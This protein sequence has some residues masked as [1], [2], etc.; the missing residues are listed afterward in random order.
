MIDS[1]GEL[2]EIITQEKFILWLIGSPEMQ[3][4]HS[5]EGMMIGTVWLLKCLKLLKDK[6][7][8]G[9]IDKMWFV[10]DHSKKFFLIICMILI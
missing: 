6:G 8:L 10:S 1:V 2:L 4:E 3:K 5:S 9:S 7:M